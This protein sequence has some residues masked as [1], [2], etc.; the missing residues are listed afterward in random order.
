MAVL[1]SEHPEFRYRPAYRHGL[2][3]LERRNEINAINDLN[4]IRHYFI[5]PYPSAELRASL[6]V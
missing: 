6:G 5:G 3:R 2:D 4:G 1:P